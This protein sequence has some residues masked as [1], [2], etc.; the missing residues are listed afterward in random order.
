MVRQ[1]LSSSIY[2]L[3][4]IF[5]IFKMIWL[6]TAGGRT[7]AAF[8]HLFSLSLS[9]SDLIHFS[10]CANI[11][12]EDVKHAEIFDR[13][14]NRRHRLG[15]RHV[16]RLPELSSSLLSNAT[17]LVS[18]TGLSRR[19]DYSCGPGK[20]CANGACCGASGYCGYGMDFPLQTFVLANAYHDR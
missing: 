10:H 12:I 16:H 4:Y 2:I 8:V 3:S 13:Q 15:D 17:S 19:D 11:P 6:P 9:F 1:S 20:P 7:Q 14:I 18:D 5:S